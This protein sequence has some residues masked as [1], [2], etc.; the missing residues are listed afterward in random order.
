MKKFVCS[1]CGYVYEGE[2]APEFCPL[3]KAPASKFIEQT[4]EKTWAAEHVVGVASDV[5]EDIKADLRANFEGECS[6]VGMYLAMARVA[7]R[8][9]YPE[10]GLY[11]EK[12][13]YEEAEHA[14]KFAELLGE[15]VSPSTKENLK[16]RVEAENGATAGKF[17]LAKRAKALNLDAIHDTVHE[18]ARDEARHGKAFEGLLKRYFGDK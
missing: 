9:G 11:W 18:M 16:V 6:E 7:H 5:P 1:V 17:D 4:E 10:I 3:C 15:V 12:A 13:A 2:A 8:E 14:A